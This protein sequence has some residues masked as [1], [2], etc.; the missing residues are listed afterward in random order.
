MEDE[1]TSDHAKDDTTPVDGARPMDEPAVEAAA[2]PETEQ[3]EGAAS[4]DYEA[5]VKLLA[6]NEELKDRALRVAADMENLRRR[7]AR[8]VH[9]ARAYAIS[10]FARSWPRVIACCTDSTIGST[11]NFMASTNTMTP[12]IHRSAD[13]PARS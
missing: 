5:L 10:A 9:D 8:D 1:M 2:Q 12:A 11:R 13:P 6:E 7:T 4:G 3:N